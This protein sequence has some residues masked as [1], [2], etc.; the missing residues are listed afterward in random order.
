M[1]TKDLN[2]QPSKEDRQMSPGKQKPSHTSH[3]IEWLFSMG[4]QMATFCP[5]QRRNA[6]VTR[7]LANLT[8]PGKSKEAGL[9][10]PLP[11]LQKQQTTAGEGGEGI[12]CRGPYPSKLSRGNAWTRPAACSHP[13]SSRVAAFEAM[14]GCTFSDGYFLAAPAPVGNPPPITVA[15]LSQRVLQAGVPV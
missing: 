13:E 11:S 12:I 10:K 4:I 15:M 1:G 9:T 14:L 7:E 6:F 2:R 5:G 3:Q 8:S